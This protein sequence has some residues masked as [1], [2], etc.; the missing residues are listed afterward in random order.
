V[1]TFMFTD[2]VDSTPLVEAIGDA[3]W[4]HVRRWHDETLRGLFARYRGE[5]VDHA[6]DGFFVSFETAAHAVSCAVEIQRTLVEHRRSHGFSP[7]LRIAL[8]SASAI[9]R[10]P[11]YGGKGVHTA[12]RIGAHAGGGEILASVE[13][14]AEAGGAFPT[15]EPRALKL[16]G[17]GAPV[18]VATLLWA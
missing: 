14:L 18:E 2:I 9:R 10:G 4:L 8:H 5:E 6:G 15:T 7:T 1:R 17:I 12:A 3:A 16:K 11:G 13:T